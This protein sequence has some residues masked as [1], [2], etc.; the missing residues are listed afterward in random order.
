MQRVITISDTGFTHSNNSE[1]FNVDEHVE[2]NKILAEG[3]KI[4]NVIARERSVTYVLSNSDHDNR[5]VVA[6]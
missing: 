2:L 5:P 1:N 4:Q 3:Y 6:I